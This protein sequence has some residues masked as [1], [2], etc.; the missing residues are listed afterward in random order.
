MDVESN[1]RNAG[2]SNLPT[3]SPVEEG[4][5]DLICTRTVLKG[6]SHNTSADNS[7]KFLSERSLPSLVNS[8]EDL[9]RSEIVGPLEHSCLGGSRRGCRLDPI[10]YKLSNLT[11][12]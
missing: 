8:G 4:V 5:G 9:R 10:R 7:P 6:I 11:N 3:P 12:T 1:R 2:Y